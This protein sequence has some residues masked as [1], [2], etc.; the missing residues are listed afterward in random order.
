MEQTL[1]PNYDPTEPLRSPATPGTYSV[2]AQSALGSVL[3]DSVLATNLTVFVLAVPKGSAP[4]GSVL[5]VIAVPI[6]R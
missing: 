4:I 1:D 3:T 5:I 2:L 6:Q